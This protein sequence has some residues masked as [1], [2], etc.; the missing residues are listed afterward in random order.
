MDFPTVVLPASFSALHLVGDLGV[1]LGYFSSIFLL[2]CIAR[3]NFRLFSPQ[4]VLPAAF[5]GGKV[6]AEKGLEAIPSSSLGAM[7]PKPGLPTMS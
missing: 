7:A 5:I 3:A 4:K 6:P 2:Y 1:P